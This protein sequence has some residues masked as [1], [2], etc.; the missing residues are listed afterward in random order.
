MPRL[1]RTTAPALLVLVAFA[2]LLAAL[3]F[4]GAADAPLVVD[5]G[6]VVR[7]GLPMAK[8]LGNVGAAYQTTKT[9]CRC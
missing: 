6:E 4:G 2:S 3:K 8:M 9:N 1:A 7:Y 5:P